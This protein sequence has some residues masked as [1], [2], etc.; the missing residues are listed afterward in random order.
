MTRSHNKRVPPA[1][2]AEIC[3]LYREHGTIE[4]LAR[5][6]GVAASTVGRVLKR[7]GVPRRSRWRRPP[8]DRDER[9]LQEWEAAE[10]GHRAPIAKAFGFS[11][12]RSAMRAV[13]RIRNGMRAHQRAQTGKQEGSDAA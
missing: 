10:R 11:N 7:A 12:L 5:Q 13:R 6:F 8:P 9:L 1:V 3:R 2:E 4:A